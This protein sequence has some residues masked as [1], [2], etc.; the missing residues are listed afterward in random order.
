MFRNI[1]LIALIISA[2]GAVSFAQ[3]TTPTPTPTTKTTTTKTTTTKTTTP[4]TTTKVATATTVTTAQTPDQKAV[5][6]AFDKLVEGIQESDVE[7][8]MSVYQ[9]S[10][11]TLYFNNNGSVTRGYEQDKANREARYPKTTDAILTPTNVR[12]E[13][14]GTGGALLTCQWTQS[15]SYEGKSE[16]ASGR[17]TLVFKKIG[18]AWKIVHLHTSPDNPASTRPVFPS[19]KGS[20]SSPD[21]RFPSPIPPAKKDSQ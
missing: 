16:T 12:V 18:N 13:M 14:L 5:R 1:F 10:P 7:K 2:S 21:N 6:A 3:T 20:P 11:S 4:A 8:V 19:E 9:N 15:Q 17:M